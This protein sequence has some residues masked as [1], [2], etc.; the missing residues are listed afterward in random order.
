MLCYVK[1]D[2]KGWEET[3]SDLN[4]NRNGW[5]EMVKDGKDDVKRQD[6]MGKMIRHDGC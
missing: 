5:K 3:V 2:W 6:G 1:D 4:N